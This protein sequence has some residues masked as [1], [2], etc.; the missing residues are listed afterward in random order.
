[1]RSALRGLELHRPRTLAEALRL[2]RDDGPLVPFAGGTD[3]YVGLN[4]GTETA[5]RFVDL[6]RLAPLRRI[7][8]VGDTLSI[9][10]LATFTAMRR[11]RQVRA[12]LPMLARASGEV[13]GVQ[14]QNRGTL[15]GNVAN[16]SPAG[17]TLPVL[18]AVDAVVVLRSAAGER[19]VAF[20]DFY[21]GYRTSVRRPDELI[22]AIEV[23]P[24]EGAQWFRKVGTRSAQAIAKVVMAGVRGDRP[25]IAIG[26]VAPSVLRLARTEAALAA[27]AGLDA[28]VRTL[29]G[30]ISPIDDLRSTATYRRRV[31][32]NLLRRFWVE[33]G[34]APGS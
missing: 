28:A 32:G 11:S 19:R 12:R 22:A 1:M 16:G 23:P 33:T 17:D 20:A 10:A 6:W 14:I 18:A 4:F 34:P 27:G 2:L 25:R 8:L 26:S 3:I 7:A 29:E 9:G 24:V 30:E 15:G 31:A 13:G 5:T 21:T